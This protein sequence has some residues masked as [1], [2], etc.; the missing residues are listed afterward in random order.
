MPIIV[1]MS[2]KVSANW[3]PKEE[4]VVS[5]TTSMMFLQIGNG[6][7]FLLPIMFVDGQKDRKLNVIKLSGD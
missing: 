2:T 3:F 1:N 4:R 6:L 7:G 5:T